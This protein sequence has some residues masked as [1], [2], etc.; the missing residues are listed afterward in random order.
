[1]GGQAAL[2]AQFVRG[3]GRNSNIRAAF[4]MWGAGLFFVGGAQCGCTVFV[5]LCGTA[6]LAVVTVVLRAGRNLASR[7]REKKLIN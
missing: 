7:T 4:F 5:V 1:M 3:V 2:Q 6:Q